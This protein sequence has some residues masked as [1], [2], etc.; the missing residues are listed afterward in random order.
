MT[1]PVVTTP[2]TS[3]HHTALI[4]LP[5]RPKT[6]SMMARTPILSRR[7]M[8]GLGA[9]AAVEAIGTYLLDIIVLFQLRISQAMPINIGDGP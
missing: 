6:H 3:Q 8:L 9:N 1:D 5:F 2:A 4:A 7:A